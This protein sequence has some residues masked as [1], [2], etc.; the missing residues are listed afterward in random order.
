ML[1]VQRAKDSQMLISF[2]FTFIE[3][4]AIVH[5]PRGSGKTE[6]VD[7][8]I[9][10]KKHKVV[11]RCEELA[12]A[13]SDSELLSNLAKQIGYIPLFQFMTTINNMMDMAITA[14]TGQKAGKLR[15]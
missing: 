6:L 14:T 8:V 3:T 12:N 5:G 4:F 1:I 15:V 10:Q 11:I 9:K 13:R 7:Y 2:L